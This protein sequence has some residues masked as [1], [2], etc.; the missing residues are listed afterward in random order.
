MREPGANNR[1]LASGEPAVPTTPS[2]RRGVCYYADA[3]FESPIRKEGRHGLD[4]GGSKLIGL[5]VT[6]KMASH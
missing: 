5:E 4:A 1:E 3:G 6:T 2:Q